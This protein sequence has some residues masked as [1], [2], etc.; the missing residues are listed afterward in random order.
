[1][2]DMKLT[3][4]KGELIDRVRSAIYSSA[5]HAATPSSPSPSPSLQDESLLVV[6]DSID[7]MVSWLDKAQ[8]DLPQ[9]SIMILL[10]VTKEVIAAPGFYELEDNPSEVVKWVESGAKQKYGET[11]NFFLR[12]SFLWLK[13]LHEHGEEIKNDFN[14]EDFDEIADGLEKSVFD[15]D[16]MFGGTFEHRFPEV[17]DMLREY[18]M[19]KTSSNA[20][21]SFRTREEL[22]V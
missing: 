3:G 2:R 22:N 15:L 16:A 12:L 6:I 5:H 8:A 4:K 19:R 14:R 20:F 18:G 13:L 10:A 7:D 21:Q 11:T 9:N 1:M 17:I